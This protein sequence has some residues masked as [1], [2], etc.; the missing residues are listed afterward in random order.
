M[1]QTKKTNKDK[2]RITNIFFHGNHKIYLLTIPILF[3]VGH[4]NLYTIPI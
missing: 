3:N 2:F 4:A 1:I